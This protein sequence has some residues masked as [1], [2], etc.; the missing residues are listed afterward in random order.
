MTMYSGVCLEEDVPIPYVVHIQTG[1]LGHVSSRVLGCQLQIE[2]DGD[3]AS[4]PP[5]PITSPLSVLKKDL[6]IF[7]PKLGSLREG[8]IVATSGK[9]VADEV[10]RYRH[11]D[12]QYRGPA[13]QS[14]L[15]MDIGGGS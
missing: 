15:A 11:L 14:K 9:S 5:A 4:T 8:K 13:T 10:F 7:T 1:S 3:L 6:T 2:I 12:V